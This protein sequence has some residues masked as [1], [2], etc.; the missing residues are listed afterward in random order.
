MHV[1]TAFVG[2]SVKPKEFE[3]TKSGMQRRVL[4]HIAPGVVVPLFTIWQMSPT[5]PLVQTVVVATGG[6]AGVA[7]LWQPPGFTSDTM[8]CWPLATR[9]TVSFH[10][11]RTRNHRRTAESHSAPRTAPCTA[12]QRNFNQCHNIPTQDEEAEI[13][14]SI[15][16]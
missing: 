12:P 6:G 9:R 7:G 4:Q 1:E 15:V 14:F 13:F 11:G 5:L 10:L 2:K 16:F 3:R 8:D